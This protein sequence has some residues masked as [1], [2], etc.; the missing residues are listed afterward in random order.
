MFLCMYVY[1]CLNSYNQPI[2]PIKNTSN[3]YTYAFYM[4]I[5]LSLFIYLFNVCMY[6]NKYILC[7]Y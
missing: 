5:Y 1:T 6:I 2:K 7:T 4:S 3:A